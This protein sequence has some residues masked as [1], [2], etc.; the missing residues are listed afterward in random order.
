MIKI[1]LSRQITDYMRSYSQVCLFVFIGMVLAV[2]YGCSTEIEIN[3]EPQDIWALYGTL[4]P[5]DSVQDI[6][7]AMGFLPEGN[8][9][10]AAAV[11]DLS[12]KGL[13]VTLSD[14]TNEWVATQVDEVEKDSGAFFPT[15][16]IYRFFTQ[17]DDQLVPGDRYTIT[18]T[19][20][21]D[22][23][24]FL[25]S[26]TTIPEDLEFSSP[27]VTPGPGGQRCLRQ[28]NLEEEYKVV[29]NEGSALGFELRAYLDYTENGVAKQA[30]YGPT[31]VFTEDFRCLANGSVCYQFRANEI[32]LEFF[33][34]MNIQ[35]SAVYEYPVNEATRCNEVP[36][37]LPNA[38]RFEV[39]AIDSAISNYYFANDPAFTDFNTVR[40]EYT[41]ISGSGITVGIFGSV[42]TGTA[43]GQLSA[44]SMYL[45]QL[46]ETPAPTSPCEF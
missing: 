26:A 41:N 10:E 29:F 45:L 6:R 8:A 16:T 35:P 37:D 15:T 43:S 3:A 12:L 42:N 36:A 23:D 40:D 31:S 34:D 2:S 13:L 21:D 9:E 30:Q 38:F 28:I 18:A 14:G 19:K 22:P 20:P 39:T 5:A 7:I 46:N 33:Q 44:C 1:D 27:T 32:T 4:N 11:L 24:F 25:T 17:G